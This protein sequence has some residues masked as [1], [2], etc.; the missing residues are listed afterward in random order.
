MV[1][2]IQ[3]AADTPIALDGT[4]IGVPTVD[5]PD[6]KPVI[7][8]DYPQYYKKISAQASDYIIKNL[9]ASGTVKYDAFINGPLEAGLYGV[10]GSVSSSA[11]ANETTAY[12]NTFTMAN[13]L[14]M[15]TI[16]VGR[17]ALN[18]QRFND[19]RFGKMDMEL[20]PGDN[21][22]LTLT[23]QGKGG[24]LTQAAFTPTYPTARSFLFDDVGVTLGG[25]ENCDVTGL[26][27]S[28]DRGLKTA[29]TACTASARGENVFYPTT[30]NVSGHIDMFFQDYTEY[31]YWLGGSGATAPTFNQTAA[32]TKRA[33]TIHLSGDAIGDGAPADNSA[34]IFTIPAISYSDS[35][36]TDPWDDRM[37]VGFDFTALYDSTT[38]GGLAGS[39]VIKA[40]VDSDYNAQTSLV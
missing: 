19:V 16:G 32:N 1:M 26:S 20:K 5:D 40:Q 27:L 9:S 24:D 10:F 25:S 7:E 21:V 39:G 18:Y 17:D 14:P 34:L 33:L 11:I 35:T 8:K 38:E 31:A 13:T 6:M 23:A 30:I 37:M 22:G 2:A 4:K 3:S 15:W 12:I 28:I 29:R 36:I